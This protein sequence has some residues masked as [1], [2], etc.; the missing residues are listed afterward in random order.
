[1][2]EQVIFINIEIEDFTDERWA[3]ICAQIEAEAPEKLPKSN[4]NILPDVAPWTPDRE[5]GEPP[6]SNSDDLDLDDGIPF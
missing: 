6:F 3:E 5:I 1:M 2:K 4:G